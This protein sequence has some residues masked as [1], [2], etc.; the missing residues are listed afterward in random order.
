[1]SFQRRPL[2]DTVI[3]RNRSLGKIRNCVPTFAREYRKKLIDSTMNFSRKL[4]RKNPY[5]AV[6]RRAEREEMERDVKWLDGFQR[7]ALKY[8]PM[9]SP[10]DYMIK[11]TSYSNIKFGQYF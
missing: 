1:M 9:N 11:S 10:L 5:F 8:L 7:Q 4:V 6:R 3:T 2:G